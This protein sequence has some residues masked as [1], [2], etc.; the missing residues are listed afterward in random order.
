ML[1]ILIVA[2][3]FATYL[4][5]IIGSNSLFNR[6]A[7]PSLLVWFIVI[8]LMVFK[9]NSNLFRYIEYVTIILISALFLGKFWVALHLEFGVSREYEFGEFFNWIPLFFI[10][11]FFTFNGKKA[12]LVSLGFLTLTT[13]IA[14]DYFLLVDFDRYSISPIIQFHLSNMVYVIALYSLQKL[15]EV[16]LHADALRKTSITDFLTDLPNRRYMHS[17][18]SQEFEKENNLS[19]ILFDVDNFKSINDQYGHDIGDLVLIKL[20]VTIKSY[21]GEKG[22]LGR[23]GGEEFLIVL[24]NTPV[25]KATEIAEE[26][27]V[28]LENTKIDEVGRVTSSFGVAGKTENDVPHMLL[29]RADKALYEA[30]ENGKN[31]VCIKT[32]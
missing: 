31:Q 23:W 16:L 28:L 29:N 6:V 26:V 20:S 8:Y 12:L 17:L 27:R 11:I 25:I 2:S 1:P 15:K 13:I 5:I 21:L 9:Q 22:V 32:V 14:L 24:K 19:V 30:K 18:L 3:A 10:F 4:E 7:L